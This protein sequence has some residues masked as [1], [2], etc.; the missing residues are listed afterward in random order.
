MSDAGNPN[1]NPDAGGNPPPAEFDTAAF[2]ASLEGDDKEFAERKGLLKLDDKGK[3]ASPLVALQGWRN[4]EKLIGDPTKRLPEPRLDSAEELAKWPGFEKLGTPKDAK[5]YQFKRP[6]MPE[7]VQ[8]DEA[9]EQRFRAMAHKAHMPQFMFER[10]MNEEIAARTAGAMQSVNDMK[11]EQTR[12]ET[13]L[14][15]DLGA[16]YDTAIKQ[17]GM[18]AKLL[19]EEAGVD[20]GKAADYASAI[21]GSEETTRMFLHLAKMMGEGALQGAGDKGF[22]SSVSDAKAD[23]ERLKL[24][25]EFQKAYTDSGHPGHKDAVARMNRLNQ[26]AYG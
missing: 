11:A 4:S 3:P 21:L 20:P 5:D 16:G 24:D 23:I 1:P 10:I 13:V 7:G 2:Y 14:R 6:D 9:A 12:I 25:G 15:Q 22:A 26:I 19:A 17:A 18:A 8:Y